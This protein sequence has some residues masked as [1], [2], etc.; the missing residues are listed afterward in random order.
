[1]AYLN[2]TGTQQHTGTVTSQELKNDVLTLGKIYPFF[3]KSHIN[4][5][6]PLHKF[7][8]EIRNNFLTELIWIWSILLSPSSKKRK[9][10]S[11]CSS[12]N[13]KKIFCFF[14]TFGGS[15]RTNWNTVNIFTDIFSLILSLSHEVNR[16]NSIVH[17]HCKE[18]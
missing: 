10:S 4:A 9:S 17:S 11:G 1:M 13:L 3:L 2:D 15:L 16:V 5:F 7:L 8:W 18:N 14:K 6:L 12:R